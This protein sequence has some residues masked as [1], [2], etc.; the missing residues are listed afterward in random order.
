MITTKLCGQIGNQL[1]QYAVCRTVAER[2][3]YQFHIPRE[4]SGTRLF[5]NVD[6]GIP[7]CIIHHEYKLSNF[8]DEMVQKYDPDIF[9]VKDYTR[10]NGY[11]QTEKYFSENRENVKSW[12]KMEIEFPD[13]KKQLNMDENTCVIHFRGGDYASN[14]DLFLSKKFFDDSISHMRKIYKNI[15]FIV[16]TNDIEQASRFFDFKICSFGVAEDFYLIN[17][18]S[19]LIIANSTF[20]WWGAWLNKNVELV[21]APKYWFRHNISNGWW[22]P[23]DAITSGFTYV[24]RSGEIY[25]P[26]QCLRDLPPNNYQNNQ[27]GKYNG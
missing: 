24:D 17:T 5:K 27:A 3:G 4:F 15:N 16:I 11:L 1:W 22:C 23:S 9:N 13:I 25:T 10:L 18:A 8:M 7:D 21:L 19:K 2:N 12:F 20:S 6:L 26:E 14:P